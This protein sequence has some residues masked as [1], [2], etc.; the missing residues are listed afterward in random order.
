[1]SIT[2][3][4]DQEYTQRLVALENAWWK[5]AIGA[6][7]L[8]GWN[9]RRLKP[10]FTLDIG[11]G[12]GRNLRHLGGVGVGID[13]NRHSVEYARSQ[14]LET[15]TT[16]EFKSSEHARPGRF[17]SILLSHVAEH[18]RYGEY[19]D[20]LR[21]YA[22]LLRANGR[23]LTFCPQEAGYKSDSSHVEFMDFAKL[24]TAATGA[25]MQFVRDY[26]FP[27]PRVLGRVFPYNEFV[28]I[29]RKEGDSP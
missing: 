28:S 21:E 22:P 26:S 18:M 20:L 27:F 8:Y 4:R 19:V 1:M 10:G 12:I 16:E 25:G 13:H 29:S 24:R 15:Y 14:G 3:T 5:K 17:D 9:L 6:Q 23:V 11:C 7:A 2:D